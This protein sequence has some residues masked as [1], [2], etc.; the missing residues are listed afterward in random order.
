VGISLDGMRES[1]ERIRGT[2]TWDK[3]IEAIELLRGR[4]IQTTVITT[5]SKLNFKDLPKLKDLLLKKGVNWQMQIAMPFGNFQK[6][7][8]LSKEEYYA[9]ALFIAKERIRNKFE[10]LPVVGAHCYGYY[11]KVLPGCRWNGCQ[12]GISSIGITSDGNI[13]GCLSMGND[14][15]IEGNVRQKSLV[16]IWNDQG[17]F[18]YN[19]RKE[20][21]KAGPNCRECKREPE[22]GGGCNSVSYSLTGSF[23]N[24][25]YC[26]LT[27]E[28]ENS[29]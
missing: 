6:E 7:F 5:V 3:A 23:H 28:K 1:H 14:R 2:G 20:L 16:E 10:D 26:F 17:T 24:N 13:V 27:I 15:F 19:R 12:A 21:R 8:M 9:T 29:I 25:P 22:C 11:S 4:K 18:A